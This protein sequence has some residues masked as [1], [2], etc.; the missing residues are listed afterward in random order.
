M[1]GENFVEITLSDGSIGRWVLSDQD[2]EAVFAAVESI[3]G[4]PDTFWL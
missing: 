4:M 1:D 2:A 3:V